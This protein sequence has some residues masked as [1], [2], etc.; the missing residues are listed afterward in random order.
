MDV[1]KP[2][3]LKIQKGGRL[4]RISLSKKH[5][6]ETMNLLTDADSSTNTI[7]G[8]FHPRQRMTLKKCPFFYGLTN[9]SLKINID[10]KQPTC[11]YQCKFSRGLHDLFL[12]LSLVYL[13]KND[14]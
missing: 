7:Y 3:A 11:M 13:F 6:G 14:W 12:G 4:W 9:I 2:T 10:I 8:S 1:K 5:I